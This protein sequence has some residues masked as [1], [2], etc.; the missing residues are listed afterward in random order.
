M[1]VWD[2]KRF[3]SAFPDM[4]SDLDDDAPVTSG[5]VCCM[6]TS[7]CSQKRL[8]V[9]R[10]V[11]LRTNANLANS[12]HRSKFRACSKCNDAGLETLSPR[13]P[14]RSPR[15]PRTPFSC[16][17]AAHT[18]NP[19]KSPSA[20][21]SASASVSASELKPSSNSKLLQSDLSRQARPPFPSLLSA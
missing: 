13:T 21:A 2:Q 1:H 8:S 16:S 9:L 19:Q 7:R 15:F 12:G 14:A 5:M 10:T 20:S 18:Q 3:L 4:D 17:P 11:I 6:A